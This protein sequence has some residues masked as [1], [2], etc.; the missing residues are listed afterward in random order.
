MS[1]A[2]IDSDILIDVLRQQEKAKRFIETMTK[3]DHVAHISVLTE[4]EVLSGKDCKVNQKREKTEGLLALFQVVDVTQSLARKGAELRREHDIPLYD[5]IIA[6]TAL[7][8]AIPL[9][10]RNATDFKKI[11]E[12][13][14]IVPY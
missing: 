13:K 1:T 4:A 3:N 14:L 6:A 7:E 8:M 12:L 10:S 11:K 9:Y 2:I 5:A